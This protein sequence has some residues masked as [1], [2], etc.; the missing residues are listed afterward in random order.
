MNVTDT[1]SRNVGNIKLY[2]N[3][4]VFIISDFNP[5]LVNPTIQKFLKIISTVHESI[6]CVQTD[7]QSSFKLF[8]VRLKCE[9]P[10]SCSQLAHNTEHAET[11][12]LVFI[13]ANMYLLTL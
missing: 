12:H 8:T 9:S 2:V 11:W 6:S 13:T 1:L 4:P 3:Y 5:I 10:V 7:G